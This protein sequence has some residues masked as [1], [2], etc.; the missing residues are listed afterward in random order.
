MTSRCPVRPAVLAC[1]ALLLAAC[2]STSVRTP[3]ALSPEALYESRLES[4]EATAA[5]SLEGRLALSSEDDGG[6]GKFHWEDRD[7]A[8]RMSFHGA[9][10]RGAWELEADSRSAELRLADGNSYRAGSVVELVHAQLGW[11]IPVDALAWWVRGL[12]APGDS[13]EHE[14]DEKGRLIALRQQDWTV[15]FER[16]REVGEVDLP[17]RMT[18]RQAD[19][20]VK[21]AV[22]HWSLGDDGGRDE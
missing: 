2:G 19:R 20:M 18:A 10:G 21:L 3:G 15:E 7:G 9:L 11:K 1:C 13:A 22:R 4:L 6:S 14:L 5:W 8:I 17:A 16:Y 12:I